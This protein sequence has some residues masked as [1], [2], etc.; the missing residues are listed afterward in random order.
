MHT[1]STYHLG[2]SLRGYSAPPPPVISYSKSFYLGVRA[3]NHTLLHT[4]HF[5]HRIINIKVML[6]SRNT[7]KKQKRP[8]LSFFLDFTR[9]RRAR[10]RIS[11]LL[12]VTNKARVY[13][14]LRKKSERQR[15]TG[16]YIYIM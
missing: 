10:S 3:F 9:S 4:H 1:Y 5:H 7:F 11:T 2:S 12:C 16:K 15:P 13:S 6:R 8:V 14:E